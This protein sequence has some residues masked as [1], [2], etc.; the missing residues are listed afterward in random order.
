L[1]SCLGAHAAVLHLDGI[2]R[3]PLPQKRSGVFDCR[4]AAAHP[5]L[6]GMPPYWPVPHS[7]ANDLPEAELVAHGYR[8]LARSPTAGVD[9]FAKQWRSLFVFL[10]GHPEYDPLALARE[11]RRDVGRFARGERADHP[12]L[13]EHYFDRP[14][15][16]RLAAFRQRLE[17]DR[18]PALL[19]GFPSDPGLR[20]GRA[21]DWQA[22]AVSL[23]RNWLACIA[24][25]EP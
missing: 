21:E 23:L 20:P 12:A 6:A 3:Q 22:A 16:A 5:L 7:R 18:D 19:D 13:P 15:E 1:W 10:Q 8:V 24:D 17:R 14:T 2:A 4:R 25:R 11:Y 9:L